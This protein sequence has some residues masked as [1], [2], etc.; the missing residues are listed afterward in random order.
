MHGCTILPTSTDNSKTSFIHV[1]TKNGSTVS[2]E[3]EM[4]R[5]GEPSHAL[6]LDERLSIDLKRSRDDI[7]VMRADWSAIAAICICTA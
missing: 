7:L 6:L 3:T 1:Q 5:A 4:H 2:E